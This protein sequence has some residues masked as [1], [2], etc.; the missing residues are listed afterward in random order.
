MTPRI[1]AG[2]L[3]RPAVPSDIPALRALADATWHAAY[4]TLLPAGQVDHMLARFYAPERIA[5]EMAS[6][7]SWEFVVADG[8]DAGFLAWTF[9][10]SP[11]PARARLNKLYLLPAFVGRGLGQACLV[12]FAGS[13]ASRGAAV[14]ELGVNKGNERALRAYRRAGFEVAESVCTDIGGGFVMDDFILRRPA[15]LPSSGGSA[16]AAP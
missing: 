6:G 2:I 11:S 12:H 10:P 8:T 7:V 5:E 15:V 9:L 4:D 3:F 1:P 13:A 14:L 16:A